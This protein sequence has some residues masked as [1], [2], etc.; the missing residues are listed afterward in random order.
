MGK[1]LILRKTGLSVC[2]CVME[3]K[4]RVCVGAV[5]FRISDYPYK[6]QTSV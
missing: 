3:S 1:T 4:C 5:C 2:V 6:L